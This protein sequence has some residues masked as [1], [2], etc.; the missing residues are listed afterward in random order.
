MTDTKKPNEALPYP[1]LNLGSD[2]QPR[3]YLEVKYRIALFRDKYPHGRITTTEVFHDPDILVEKT[4]PV[5]DKYKKTYNHIEK[6]GTGR[7]RFYAV[8][9][10]GE[11]GVGTG[12]KT[13]D[14]CDFPD[15]YEKAESGSIGRALAALGFG[16]IYA[17][18]LDEGDRIVDAG[19]SSSKENREEE[20]PSASTPQQK[21][22]TT[23]IT[24][25]KE[26]RLS[27]LQE[28]VLFGDH[29]SGE[30]FIAFCTLINADPHHV[31]KWNDQT[32]ESA[33]QKLSQYGV[34]KSMQEKFSSYTNQ[35]TA[36]AMQRFA[37]RVLKKSLANSLALDVA[38]SI[39]TLDKAVFLVELAKSLDPEMAKIKAIGATYADG[40]SSIDHPLDCFGHAKEADLIKDYW[41]FLRDEALAHPEKL[42]DF[43]VELKEKHAESWKRL[44]ASKKE[45]KVS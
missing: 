33:H 4:I 40:K 35:L 20:K 37:K 45:Q 14:G 36:T 17:M 8:V 7:S 12:S 22:T 30:D 29:L 42:K 1:L 21:P 5:Y 38:R 34:P 32:R 24:L 18:D 13:E 26:Q 23:T 6:K 27:Y 11:G 43:P 3:M 9:E 25:T 41:I 44:L 16:T 2:N 31:E 10:D 39:E 28:A 15:H 19:V